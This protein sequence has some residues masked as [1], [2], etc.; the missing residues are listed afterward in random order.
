ME[1]D[2]YELE[3]LLLQPTCLRRSREIEALVL[4]KFKENDY[5]YTTLMG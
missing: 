5:A 2:Q 1:L 4:E 3:S